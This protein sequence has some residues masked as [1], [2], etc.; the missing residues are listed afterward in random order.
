MLPPDDPPILSELLPDELPPEDPPV[1][2]V[3]EPMEPPLVPPEVELFFF[4]VDFL[5]P[6]LSLML[7]PP[8]VPP[9][10]IELSEP[11]LLEPAP[12]ELPPVP[13]PDVPLLMPWLLPLELPP[14]PPP[15]IPELLPPDVPPPVPPV[16]PP[17][18]PEQATSP[19]MNIDTNAK[20][21]DFFIFPPDSFLINDRSLTVCRPSLTGVPDSAHSDCPASLDT[22][23]LSTSFPAVYGLVTRTTDATRTAAHTARAAGAA[24][25]TS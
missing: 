4:F 20:D 6:V 24:R 18:P 12:I 2:S 17:P 8:L 15:L 3:L 19:S 21:N 16:L 14:V 9:P 10:D 25:T 22:D 23:Y 1:V 11:L 5:V 13:P 7:L